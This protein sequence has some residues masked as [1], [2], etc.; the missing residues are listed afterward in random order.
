MPRA[1][2]LARQIADAVGEDDAHEA[3]ERA[4]VPRVEL[5]QVVQHL[6]Q[7]VLHEIVG[8]V[9][10][11]GRQRQPAVRPALQPRLVAPDQ[12]VARAVVAGL[13]ADHELERG[14]RFPVVVVAAGRGDGHVGQQGAGEVD[15]GNHSPEPFG[16]RAGTRVPHSAFKEGSTPPSI[17]ISHSE[18][19][20][21]AASRS[22]PRVFGPAWLDR[23]R[24]SLDPPAW[25][26]RQSPAAANPAQKKGCP[27]WPAARR[28][29]RVVSAA[30]WTASAVS[31]PRSNR[32]R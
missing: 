3:L 6:Q 17:R 9:A 27:D 23:G 20:G 19:L 7:G 8:F 12:Q 26:Y 15:R 2:P 16:R 10:A 24:G 18:R 4:F 22:W 11:A 13:G 21:D 29:R 31:S 30:C 14:E 28:A 1:G 32:P 5:V 25:G